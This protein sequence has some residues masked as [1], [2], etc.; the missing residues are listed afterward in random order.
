MEE[1]SRF[2]PKRVSSAA[3]DDVDGRFVPVVIMRRG[4]AAGRDDH[5]MHAETGCARRAGRNALE[6]WQLL[7]REVCVRGVYRD[8]RT[9]LGHD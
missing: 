7:L 4:F 3:L 8:D 5:E 9:V 2:G 1:C 6:V